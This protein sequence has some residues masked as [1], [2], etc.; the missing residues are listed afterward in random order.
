M[1][2]KTELKFGSSLVRGAMM[3]AVAFVLSCAPEQLPDD[4][5]DNENDDPGN[6]E[7]PPLLT[8]KR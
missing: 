2:K 4:N 5:K 6:V 3:L 8:R 1:I 7:T